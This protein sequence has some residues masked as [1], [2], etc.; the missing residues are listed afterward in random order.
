[1]LPRLI[2][3]LAVF[4]LV[5]SL[6]SISTY[7][8]I[9]HMHPDLTPI[10]KSGFGVHNAISKVREEQEEQSNNRLLISVRSSYN[11]QTFHSPLRFSPLAYHRSSS[12]LTITMNLSSLPKLG[13]KLVARFQILSTPTRWHMITGLACL[14]NHSETC[15]GSSS[16]TTK[17]QRT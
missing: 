10:D 6:S 1:M 3:F 9:D 17:H 8:K 15:T 13:P 7:R 2:T 4:P 14:S 11:Q 12:P 5:P 16:T